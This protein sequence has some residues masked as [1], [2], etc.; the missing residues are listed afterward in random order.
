MNI[1]AYNIEVSYRS[2]PIMYIQH[3]LSTFNVFETIIY[4]QFLCIDTSCLSIDTHLHVTEHGS[5]KMLFFP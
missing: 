4:Y 3:D 5:Q 2:K 1:N